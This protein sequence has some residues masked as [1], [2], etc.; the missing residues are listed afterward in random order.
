MLKGKNRE[1]FE[2][3]PLPHS[4]CKMDR[5]CNDTIGLLQEY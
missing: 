2:Y 3:P 4:H 5:D 1:T